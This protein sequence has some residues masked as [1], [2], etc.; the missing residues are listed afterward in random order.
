MFA[1]LA[2]ARIRRLF[3]VARKAAP[4][5]IF[6]DELDAVGGKRGSDFSGEKDQTLNQLLVEMDGFG[7][8]EDVVV[9]A[10]S[11]LLE[12]LDPALLRPGRFDRQ[13]LVSPPDLKGRQEILRVHTADK[14]IRGVDFEVVARQTSGLTGAEL[15]NICN[16]AAIHAGRQ[17]R[18][19]VI[20]E[21]FEWA[22]ERVVAGMQ[23]RKV[24]NDHE[25]QVIAYHEAGHALCAEV[26]DSQEKT[27]RISIIP[28]GKALGYT[29]H[30]PQEDR[31]LK[32]KEE[33]TDWMVVGLGGR[34]AESIVF[35][36]ITTGAAND[37][38]KVYQVS[39]SMVTDYGM[40]TSISSRRLPVDDYSVSEASRRIVD[41]EQQELTDE[42]WRRAKKLISANRPLL[43]AFAD[44]LLTTEV[45]ERE[46]ID[47]LLADHRARHLQP[48]GTGLHHVAYQTDDIDRTLGAV[49]E[50][51]LELIDQEPRIG[52]R[53]SRVAFLHP[54]S[55]GG[56]LTELVEPVH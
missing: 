39:R 56:V 29:L 42:A 1:G 46:D 45:L 24:I 41:E 53:G 21:N 5:I 3:R 16:E 20:Q 37:L 48:A 2:A 34:V 35:G 38:E 43:N 9:M 33:M 14:P 23:T 10:A 30:L 15:A 4:A 11:N 25:K 7:T 27:H 44:R 40:G 6:I 36:E 47:R 19:H 26:L 22:L 31:Y 50:A 8:A 54:R 17:Q 32:T 52:I 13:I 55:T 28:R 18:D 51:G 49:R 12:K